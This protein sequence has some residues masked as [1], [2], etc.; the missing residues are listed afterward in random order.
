MLMVLLL[1]LVRAYSCRADYP[2]EHARALGL[3]CDSG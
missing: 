2:A 1:L 3:C